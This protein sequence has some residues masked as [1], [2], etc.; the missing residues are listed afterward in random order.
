MQL[1]V[2]KVNDGFYDQNIVIIHKSL[3]HNIYVKYQMTY[4]SD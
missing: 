4:L 2:R 3:Y 1:C